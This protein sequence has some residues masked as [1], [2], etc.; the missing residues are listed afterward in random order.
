MTNAVGQPIIKVKQSEVR[1]TGG[2][3][4]SITQT[5]NSK[6]GINRN[7]Y[8]KDGNQTKQ[9]SNNDHGHKAES[10]YGKHGEHAH[11]YY[12]DENG[13]LQRPTRE[14]NEEE[15]KENGDIL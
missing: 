7:Y 13:E 1:P 12:Y 14:L 3:P 5:E 9:I 10:K 4:N 8:D 11:D 6:G 2:K 15:R